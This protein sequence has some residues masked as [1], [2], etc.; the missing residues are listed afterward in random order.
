MI[1]VMATHRLAGILSLMG[2]QQSNT[3]QGSTFAPLLFFFPMQNTEAHL[4][5]ISFGFLNLF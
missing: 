4:P 2:I 1:I 3:S 5:S